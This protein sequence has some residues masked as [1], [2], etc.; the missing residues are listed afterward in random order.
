[1]VNIFNKDPMFNIIVYDYIC[2]IIY[3]Y[4][5]FLVNK[6]QMWLFIHVSSGS[7]NN[8]IKYFTNN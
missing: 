7:P 5:F 6:I 4:L 3:W 1:M 8:I 2:Y